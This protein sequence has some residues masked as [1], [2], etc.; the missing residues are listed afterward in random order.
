MG[1]GRSLKMCVERLGASSLLGCLGGFPQ[2][3]WLDFCAAWFLGF[4]RVREEASLQSWMWNSHHVFPPC[5][6]TIFQCP[7]TLKKVEKQT[8]PLMSGYQHR[9]GWGQATPW[10]EWHTQLVLCAQLQCKVSSSSPDLQAHHCPPSWSHWLNQFQMMPSECSEYK[11]LLRYPP[12]VQ[13]PTNKEKKLPDPHTQNEMA[14]YS[15]DDQWIPL[16]NEVGEAEDSW[17]P[18]TTSSQLVGT[19]MGPH[20]GSGAAPP[21]S[22]LHPLFFGALELPSGLP[23]LKSVIIFLRN[24]PCF[25]A[26]LGF[27]PLERQSLESSVHELSQPLYY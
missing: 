19:E 16:K 22:F 20:L 10:G 1:S 15:M 24:A 11:Q 17:W 26:S 6:I 21:A 23:T 27:H 25:M 9:E 13:W 7:L 5:F 2:E 4:Q 8:L 12:C 3:I 14:R 18:L